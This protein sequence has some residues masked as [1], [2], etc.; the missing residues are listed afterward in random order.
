MRAFHLAAKPAVKTHSDWNGCATD[1]RCE[2]W[3]TGG[4]GRARELAHLRFFQEV[5]PTNP[6]QTSPWTDPEMV[7]CAEIEVPPDSIIPAVETV[8][9]WEDRVLAEA[10][11]RAA[12][13]QAPPLNP[14]PSKKLD[15]H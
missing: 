4:E 5:T 2:V 13:R 12:R 9:G 6:D 14:D 1:R 10:G 11:P 8:F 15:Q 3:T 7:E